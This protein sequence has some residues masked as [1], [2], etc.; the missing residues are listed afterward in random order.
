ME[1]IYLRREEGFISMGS[2]NGRKSIEDKN[3]I[4][5]G[6]VA[7]EWIIADAYAAPSK[8]FDDF[9]RQIEGWLRGWHK[10]DGTM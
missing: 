9:K 6:P 10:Y 8:R 1:D 2:F 5:G 4:Y 7:T 3:V